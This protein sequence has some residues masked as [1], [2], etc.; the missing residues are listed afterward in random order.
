MP[1]STE[2]DQAIIDCF[3][4]KNDAFNK[5][6]AIFCGFSSTTPTKAGGNVTEPTLGGY[7]RKQIT[8]ANFAAA[9][10]SGGTQTVTANTAA[11]TFDVASV[12]W[13][14]T[15]ANMTHLVL[16]T[17]ATAGTFIGFKSLTTPKPV[18]AG[19]TASIAIGDLDIV[20]GG[21]F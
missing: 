5:P 9:A 8:A 16:Y 7:I 12:D 2:I 20:L 10:D 14:A 17:A 11:C 13:H 6:A 21:T 15:N 1:F 18:L 4:G 19:D 3:T